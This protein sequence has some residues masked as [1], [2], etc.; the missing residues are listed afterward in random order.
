MSG[1][2]RT[3]A[4]RA[5]GKKDGGAREW[6]ESKSGLPLYTTSRGVTVECQAVAMTL[7]VMEQRI[8]DGFAWPSP[9]TYLAHFGGPGDQGDDVEMDYDEDAIKDAPEEDKARWQAYLEE[10]A[11]L[12]A[13]MARRIDKARNRI[14]A[15]EGVKIVSG[16]PSVDEWAARYEYIY[17]A[18]PPADPLERQVQYFT[19]VC[20][21]NMGEDILNIYLG[22]SI[23]SGAE[24]ER[25]AALERMFRSQMD[26]ARSAAWGTAV[27]DG[28]GGAG[29]QE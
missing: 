26:E 14:F 20:I 17:G 27:A 7:S 4:K 23:A 19:D 8:R 11:R 25:V 2:A 13:E 12:Q 16:A 1:K 22:I 29:A 18:S 5:A 21:G 6:P 24:E 3:A 28:A 10:T 15:L 9:P